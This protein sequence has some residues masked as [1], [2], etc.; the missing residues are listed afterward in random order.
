M[1]VFAQRLIDAGSGEPSIMPPEEFTARSSRDYERYG[2]ADPLD[3][4]L[5][6]D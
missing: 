3:R 2:Q 5:K 4:H 6:V 1:P